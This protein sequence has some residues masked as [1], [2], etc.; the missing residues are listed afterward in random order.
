MT[1]VLLSNWFIMA[2]CVEAI[3]QQAE[4]FFPY[5]DRHKKK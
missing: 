2:S 5:D 1:M 4:S 3:F